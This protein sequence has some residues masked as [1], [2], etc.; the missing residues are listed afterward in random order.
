M[1]AEQRKEIQEIMDNFNYDEKMFR[2]LEKED[3]Q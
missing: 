1:T 2:E 3:E